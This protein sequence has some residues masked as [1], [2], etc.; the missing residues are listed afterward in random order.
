[1]NYTQKTLSAALTLS[2]LA[3][4][5]SGCAGTIPTAAGG[6]L[7]T[8]FENQA[9]VI[10]TN[11][12]YAPYEFIGCGFELL[13][14][15]FS[16]EIQGFD[17]ALGELIGEKLSE[18]AGVEIKVYWKNMDF[19]GLLGSLQ[20]GQIDLIA[21]AMSPSEERELVADFST[22][23]YEAKTVI[24]TAEGLTLT[25]LDDLAGLDVGAQLGTIQQGYAD[26]IVTTGTVKAVADL[27]TLLLDLEVG[28][29]DA[30]IV[31]EPVANTMLGTNA[32]LV[33]H[34]DLSFADDGAGSAFAVLNGKT[35]L[36]DLINEL[37]AELQAD[38]T[39]DELFVAAL[40]DAAAAQ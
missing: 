24:I 8:I 30:L 19:D 9:L 20:A 36:L 7:D 2:T 40:V 27:A 38:G 39:M 29:I 17:I 32:D 21:A 18:E 35:E 25:S 22:I 6:D 1:M 10:G 5:L 23:Y 13:G 15:C 3:A 4:T 16:Q 31:E 37:I 14:M 34:S 11:A 26:E 28:N 12:E 33:I